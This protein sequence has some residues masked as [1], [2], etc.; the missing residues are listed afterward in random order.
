MAPLPLLIA[1]LTGCGPDP[2]QDDVA[3]YHAAMQPLV[4]RNLLLARGFLDIASQVKKNTTDGAGIAARM[5]AELTPLADLLQQQAAALTPATAQLGDTHAIL[6]HAWT[7]RAGSYHALSSAWASGD[8]AAFDAARRRN[9][10]AK[11][12]E[13]RYFQSVNAV[14]APYGLELDQYPELLATPN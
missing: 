11:L 7:E 13:E 1:L 5:D 3:E 6:V 2:V 8:P 9:L 12:E 4:A 14:F 10:Q